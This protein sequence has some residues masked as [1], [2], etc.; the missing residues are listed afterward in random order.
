MGY[1]ITRRSEYKKWKKERRKLAEKLADMPLEPTRGQA[2]WTRGQLYRPAAGPPPSIPPPTGYIG[3]R[4][5]ADIAGWGRVSRHRQARGGKGRGTQTPVVPSA[6][7]EIPLVPEIPQASPEGRYQRWGDQYGPTGV[8]DWYVPGAKVPGQPHLRDIN[9]LLQYMAPEDVETLTRQLYVAG[10]GAKGPFREYLGATGYGGELA[11]PGRPYEEDLQTI[12]GILGGIKNPTARA[13][14]QAVF[15]AYRDWTPPTG[16]RSSE[17]EQVFKARV[18]ELMGNIPKAAQ[19]YAAAIQRLV[20][21]TTR[22]PRREWYEMPEAMRTAPT[23]W[24]I[25]AG[26][27]RNPAWM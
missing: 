18:E 9:K 24:A 7:P 21:P 20:V 17:Q 13:W 1:D 27:T 26:L 22:D 25:A 11:V 19:P 14:A 23:N 3:G 6:A 4:T 8:G 16:M 15:D 12:S 5:E 2:Y 10:K